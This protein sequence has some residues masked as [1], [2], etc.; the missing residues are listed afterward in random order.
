[1]PRRAWEKDSGGRSMLIQ[2]IMRSIR[3]FL[4]YSSALDDGSR[5]CRCVSADSKDKDVLKMCRMMSPTQRL[6]WNRDNYG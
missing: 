2:Y 1:M 5:I 4:S 3:K 6:A